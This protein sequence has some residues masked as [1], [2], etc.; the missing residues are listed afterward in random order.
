MR[1]LAAL[2]LVVSLAL[3]ALAIDFYNWYTLDTSGT[4]L[5]IGGRPGS[6]AFNGST[7]YVGTLFTDARIHRINGPLSAPT[8]AGAFAQ[9]GPATGTTN[10]FVNLDLQGGTIIAGTNNGGVDPDVAYTF[11]LN[12]NLIGSANSAGLNIQGSG[13]DRFDGAA[14]DPGWVGGGGAGAGVSLFAFG[15]GNRN[16]Y[17]SSF[18]P[19]N[20]A[21]NIFHPSLG[22]GTRDA[23]YAAGTGDLFI[24]YVNGIG[25]G[26]RVGPH[27]FTMLDGST[28]GMEPIVTLPDGFNSAI[29]VEYLPAWGGFNLVLG[30]WRSSVGGINFS[31]RIKVFDAD[32][33][34]QGLAQAKAVN[35]LNA[36]GSGPFD[37]LTVAGSIY[38]FS[39]DAG[40]GLLAISDWSNEKIYIFSRNAIPE[41]AT[42]GLLA[43]GLLALRRR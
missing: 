15:N 7:L 16:H 25:R 21:F 5:A 6:V 1:K 24:R 2:V 10:G 8:Y 14:V 30:N 36:D 31:T 13:G 20:N 38:D 4:G 43:L 27:N 28:A 32:A 41:P 29:N 42:L 12:G 11:D 22:T 3:P 18:N 35:W 23:R 9:T 19:I 26:K 39:Y 34:G 17:D 40:S 33:T 37:F